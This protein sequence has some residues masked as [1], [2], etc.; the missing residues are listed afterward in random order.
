MGA[1]TF[2]IVVRGEL[3][4]MITE[5]LEGFEVVDREDTEGLAC[6]DWCRIKHV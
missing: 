1:E 5:E 3:G 4:P 2:D 6:A